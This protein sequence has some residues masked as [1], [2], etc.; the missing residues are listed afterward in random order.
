MLSTSVLGRFK[1]RENRQSSPEIQRTQFPLTLAWA[2][3]VPKV[4]GLTL[5]EVV[6]SF[7]LFGQHQFNCGQV[8]VALSR[9]KAMSDLSL[10]GDIN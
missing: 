9:M 3:T 5:P 7:K 8:Y 2:C 6:F 1:V 4:Q 10:I